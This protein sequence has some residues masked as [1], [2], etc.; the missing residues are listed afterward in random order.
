MFRFVITV[1]HD[2]V[3]QK[4][5]YYPS[6]NYKSIIARRGWSNIAQT[7]FNILKVRHEVIILPSVGRFGRLMQHDMPVTM[8][9]LG[10]NRNRNG[11][12]S[13]SETE[14]NNN[15]AADIDILSKLGVQLDFHITGSAIS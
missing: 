5:W 10:Q 14:S 7:Q 13:F 15:A 8:H 1:S 12:Q 9:S 3:R 4:L 6:I 2:A 11:G